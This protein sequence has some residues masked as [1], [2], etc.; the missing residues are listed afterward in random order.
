VNKQATGQPSIPS[1]VAMDPPNIT[2]DLDEVIAAFQQYAKAD[3]S[4]TGRFTW[5]K[6]QL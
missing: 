1:N 4:W 3:A 6:V 2:T 5:H